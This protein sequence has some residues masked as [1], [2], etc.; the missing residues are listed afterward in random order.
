MEMYGRRLTLVGT[1]VPFIVGFYLMGLSYYVNYTPLLYIGRVITGLVTGAATP[2]A[3]IYVSECSS[4]R[5]RGTLGSFPATFLAL[6]ILIAYVI[7]AFVEWQ[8][9]CFILGSFPIC[10][11]LI[12]LLMPETPRGFYPNIRK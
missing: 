3:Q 1:S 10:Y 5:V 7:G 9:L 6:G 2:P 8:I 11:G 4:P 12:M